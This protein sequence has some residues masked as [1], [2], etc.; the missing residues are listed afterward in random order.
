MRSAATG[1]PPTLLPLPL[2]LRL[3]L[4]LSVAPPAP[5]P[6][7]PRCQALLASGTTVISVGHR[8]TLVAYHKQVLVL[9][10]THQGGVPGPWRL[11]PAAEFMALAA[12]MN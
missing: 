12:E 11:L 7:P 1:L 4:L 6:P 3:R 5:P 2:L 8:P 9:G 10:G